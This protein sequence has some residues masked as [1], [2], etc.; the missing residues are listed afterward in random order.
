MRHLLAVL[1]ISIVMVLDPALIAQEAAAKGAQAV[2]KSRLRGCTITLVLGD[3]QGSSSGTLTPA[4]AK[5]LTDLKN[6]LPYKAYRP[7]DTAYI[8]GLNGPHL[9]LGGVDGQ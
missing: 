4:A 2:E 6:F 8:I 9:T 3:T 7:L 5:A 1:A